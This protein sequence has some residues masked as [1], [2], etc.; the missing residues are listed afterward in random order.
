MN[1]RS[2][3]LAAL[4]VGPVWSGECPAGP[5]KV[6][7]LVGQSNMQ[8]HAHVRTLPHIGMDPRTED[9]L[10]VIQD[11]TGNPL[12]Y[13]DIRISYLSSGGEKIG[14][15][16][17]GFGADD[18][19]IGPELTFGIYVQRALQEPIL[20]IKTAWG[21]KSLHTDFR[22]PSAGPYPFNESQLEQFRKQ[23]KDLDQVRAD[24]AE[25]TGHYYRLTVEHVKKVLQ[26]LKQVCPD[27]DERQGYKLAGMVW[28][29]GWNDMV[30][31]GTY[32]DRDRDGGYD[33]YSKVLTQFI[34][35]IRNDLQ[36]PKLPFVIGV[37]GA[38]GPV[39]LYLPDQKRYA[40]IHQ[41]FRNA[42]AAP[43]AEPE[44]KQNVAAVQ[45]EKYWD[46]ELVLLRARE[47]KL[48]RELK[49]LRT[50]GEVSKEEERATLEKM[51]R[52]EFTERERVTLETGVSNFEFH[53]LGCAKIMAQI[54]KGFAEA[55]L[56]LQESR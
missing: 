6:F 4:F 24:K 41:N 2:I 34:R 46:R 47:E 27:Y 50:D 35:D 54:G 52:E 53:Y 9:L 30:D 17:T 19:K 3:F 48:K 25:A 43:A 49:Q 44:F 1:V 36:A 31:R 13:E 23:K 20:I 14:A 11:D 8:G 16:T 45:T 33:L 21:G 15:L 37:M 10:G 42:M 56:E 12:V 7:I 5:L 29:Q 18:N 40:G 55:V 39:E 32:P 22:P 28:F 38:G 51:K 26:N